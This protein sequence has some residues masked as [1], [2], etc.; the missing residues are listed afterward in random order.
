[1]RNKRAVIG[2]TLIITLLCLYYLSF[3]LVTNRIQEE[4]TAYS[5]DSLG[6]VDFDRKQ[7]Y[8]DSIWNEPVYNF[9]GIEYTFKE[10]K[11]TELSFV[12]LAFSIL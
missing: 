2:L 8:L 7:G 3:S 6:N 9:L 4:A 12:V 11:N 1:M 10:I 5:R